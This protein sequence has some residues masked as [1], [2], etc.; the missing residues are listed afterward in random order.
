[1]I[2]PDDE[3]KHTRTAARLRNVAGVQAAL[4]RAAEQA[5]R[6]HAQAGRKVAVWRDNHVVWE[7]PAIPQDQHD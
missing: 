1:M 7:S 5:L 4:R 2:R 6:E 3:Q